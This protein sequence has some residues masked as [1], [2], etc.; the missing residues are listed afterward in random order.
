MVG[1]FN[2]IVNQH[3]KKKACWPQP[4]SVEFFKKES[5]KLNCWM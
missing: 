2:D 3:K 1:Y 5:T 4:G